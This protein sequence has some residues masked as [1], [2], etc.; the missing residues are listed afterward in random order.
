MTGIAY[1]QNDSATPPQAD[2]SPAAK[3][4]AMAR[5]S[6][7]RL[8]VLLRS[9]RTPAP[10][11]PLPDEAEAASAP[12]R[13]SVWNRLSAALRQFRHAP[14]PGFTAT[15]RRIR[16]A[17][18]AFRH[19][20]L[21]LHRRWIAP[22]LAAVIGRARIGL[23]ERRDA[24]RASLCQTFAPASV[25][26]AAR[27]MGRASLRHLLMPAAVIAAVVTAGAHFL[28]RED[29][30]PVTASISAPPESVISA[31]T[32]STQAAS[33]QQWV[34]LSKP[35][36]LYSIDAPEFARLPVDHQARR[37]VTGNGR[38]DDFTVGRF[39]NGH[40]FYAVRLYRPGGERPPES[41]LFVHTVRRL[42]DDGMA[43][44][45]MAAGE[46]H[47]TKFGP[48]QAADA[49]VKFGDQE[50]TCLSFRLAPGDGAL[51]IAGLACGNDKKPV[52]RAML[53]CFIDRMA[54][55]AAGED[56]QLRQIF[57]EAE[58]ARHAG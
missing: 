24:A 31:Q 50:R 16:P 38:I 40:L 57:S 41:T 56:S 14:P 45:R 22:R 52:D 19:H 15:T 42:A 47:M 10:S 44:V 2:A 18:L 32:T 1:S 48:A 36:M 37:H 33:A 30:P 39:E 9:E 6:A 46:Q 3:P 53:T 17:L 27:F 51:D 54:L 25:L 4:A 35:L 11:A 43:L 34:R 5:F 58:L 12:A 20:S 49:V 26:A 55:L 21:A 7:G 8:L 13:P 23:A 29:D 28:P